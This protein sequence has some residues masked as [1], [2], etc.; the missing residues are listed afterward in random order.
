MERNNSNAL[1]RIIG[2]F[3]LS[4][5]IFFLLGVRFD[6]EPLTKGL[7]FI[8]PQLLKTRL[9]ESVFYLHS[10][11]PL[12]NLFVG[13]ILKIFPQYYPAAF[14]VIYYLMGMALGM[15]LFML[16]R[17][18]NVHIHIAT[19]L[20]ILFIINPAVILYENWLLY[21]YPAALFFTAAAL[22]LHRYLAEE[23]ALD[24]FLF[25]FLL[26]CLGLTISI[27]HMTWF[28]LFFILI[29]IY[30]RRRWKEV[31]AVG[32][33]PLMILSAVY[34]KNYYL[35]GTFTLSRVIMGNALINMSVLHVPV[36][37]IKQL[38]RD[39]KISLFTGIIFFTP[40]EVE[41]EHL[42]EKYKN[43]LKNLRH[44]LRII[45]RDAPA[46]TP[47]D[48]IT[49][50][51]MEKLYKEG[52]M[53]IF[54]R[55]NVGMQRLAEEQ[56]ADDRTNKNKTAMMKM[57]GIPVL[58]QRT[59]P[60]SGVQNWNCLEWLI[61][62][63]EII[64]DG[65]VILKHYPQGYLES[66]KRAYAIYFFPG[67]TDTSFPNRQFIEGYENIYNFMFYHLNKNNAD[68]LYSSKLLLWKQFYTIKWDA[69]SLILYTFVIGFYGLLVVSGLCFLIGTYEKK[70][71]RSAFQPTV[72]FLLMNIFYV[73]ITSNAFAWM[74]SN[75]YR[76]FIDP[77]YVVL[78]GLMLTFIIRKTIRKKDN[79]FLPP[80]MAMSGETRG[81]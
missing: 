68:E 20:T 35:F 14:Q 59:K 19:V 48:Y 64:K 43:E 78:L 12:F 80:T 33:L 27:L 24:G 46:D 55:M 15:T 7:Q 37:K 21:T 23:K 67:P 49:N 52:R 9:L 81:C 47:G 70:K 58:D 56:K 66:L 41:K 32:L 31:L 62:T 26:A 3:T 76:F 53:T 10:Q 16:M 28:L 77:F 6:I 2:I 5:I 17:R 54:N 71:D 4:R 38:Y 51:E 57:T 44:P 8:D 39:G 75:R 25:F 73:T 40:P 72:L 79:E 69:V 45:M 36:D 29:V 74:G 13:L 22:F 63:E 1:F 30:K 18:L 34:L 65:C 50:E 11:P 60:A 61:V 42:E